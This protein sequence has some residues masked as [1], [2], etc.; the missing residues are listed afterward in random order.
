MTS[1]KI[2]MPVRPILALAMLLLGC[3]RP[4]GK[5]TTSIGASLPSSAPVAPRQPKRVTLHGE[6][7]I[8]DY[9]WLR[10]KDANGVVDYLRAENAYTDALM[11]P[12][13]AL[14]AK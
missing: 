14:Q 10:E 3:A 8:D 1:S 7:R 9:A 4:S 5:P 11:K 13:K 12:T 6:L 2:H